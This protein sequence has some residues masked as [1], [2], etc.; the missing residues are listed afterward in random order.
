[1]ITNLN[2][3]LLFFVFDIKNK[4]KDTNYKPP[5]NTIKDR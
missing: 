2:S 3:D 5:E 1:M 4:N